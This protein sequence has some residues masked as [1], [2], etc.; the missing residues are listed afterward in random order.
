[1]QGCLRDVRSKSAHKQAAMAPWVALAIALSGCGGPTPEGTS[2]PT[3]TQAPAILQD[4]AT[5]RPPKPPPTPLEVLASIQ[6]GIPP[7][8]ICFGWSQVW[9]SVVCHLR[10]Y[11]SDGGAVFGIY[12]LGDRKTE[13][14]YVY[15]E[16]DENEGL[17]A[18]A[19]A[20]RIDTRTMQ[21]AEKTIASRKFIPVVASRQ[22][23]FATQVPLS[24]NGRT[25][26]RNTARAG[27][28]TIEVACNGAWNRLR[29]DDS[30]FG[31]TNASSEVRAF[32]LPGRYTLLTITLSWE[33]DGERGGAQD[34]VL[35]HPAEGCDA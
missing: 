1:M 10:R 8:E 23:L 31:Q 27:G 21:E 29:V 15:F 5:A 9:K 7:L 34:A 4:A 24:I 28:A 19:P 3:V 12:L 17:I 2:P 18:A 32:A 16:A 14:E 33:H 30:T 25:F 20:D 13:S 11:S 35:I 26:R 6:R 22:Y